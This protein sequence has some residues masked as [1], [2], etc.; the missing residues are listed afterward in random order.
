MKP[1]LWAFA[2]GFT[3][4]CA[5]ASSSAQPF[6]APARAVEEEIPREYLLAPEAGAYVICVKG[7]IGDT[8]RGLALRLTHHLRQLKW[9]AYIYDY[10]AEVRREAEETLKQRYQGHPELI[11]KRTIKV[12]DQWGVLI[13][14]YKDLDGA[15]DDLEKVKKLPW[16][17]LGPNGT[18]RMVDSRTG[19]ILA[20]SPYAH[21]FATR[22]P[23]AKNEQHAS[24]APDPAWKELNRGRPY[25][26]LDCG[27]P[28]TLAIKQYQGVNVVQSRSAAN[29]F[30]DFLGLGGEPGAVLAAS[31]K[32]AE[33]MARF[34]RQHPNLKLPAYV[35][36][37][38]TS[39]VITVGAFNSQDDPELLRMKEL[40]K[41]LKLLN[42]KQG[43]PLAA[44]VFEFFR[45]PMPMQV[46]QL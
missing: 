8:S 45:E 35:L 18:D 44:Q 38:R 33:E 17:D 2:S 12:Q 20:V 6:D 15:R 4:L 29:K 26:L 36:H 37:T 11:K 21:A 32:Q 1:F 39:S 31:A 28:W 41:K 14:G 19:Q 43:N 13:G 16:P 22:N 5:T 25:N 27:Q 46:P 7:Y 42:E 3:M 40:V 34:L 24:N 9:P 10:S 30:L 23:T